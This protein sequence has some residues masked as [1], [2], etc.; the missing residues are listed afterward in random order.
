[1]APVFNPGAISEHSLLWEERAMPDLD[2]TDSA[3]L[4]VVDEPF[5][6]IRLSGKRAEAVGAVARVSEE[7]FE[8]LSKSKWSLSKS[9]GYAVRSIPVV[10]AVEGQRRQRELKMHRVVAF[11]AGLIASL[12]F[13]GTEVDHVRGDKLDNRRSLIRAATKSQNL[14]NMK[15]RKDNVS[16][17]RGV[18]WS[19]VQKRWIAEVYADN[20]CVF[21]R[22][23]LAHEY[24]EAVVA[25]RAARAVHHGE[26]RGDL[27]AG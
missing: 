23:F 26:Y 19:S 12:E 7:D 18:S 4:V 1:M 2:H 16:G 11:R 22:R 15:K 27:R 10:G 20:K 13:D 24:A 6:V 14:M 17:E 3:A 25:V 9:G 21:R 8:F 5:R